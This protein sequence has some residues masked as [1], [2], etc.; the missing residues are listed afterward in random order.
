MSIRD[1]DKV[2]VCKH[3]HALDLD[4]IEHG[5]WVSDGLDGGDQVCLWPCGHAVYHDEVRWG[6]CFACH[7][8]TDEPPF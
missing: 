5:R 4:G 3:C 1:E 6:S 8:P 7:P 2:T